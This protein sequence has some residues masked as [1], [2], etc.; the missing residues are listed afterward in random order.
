METLRILGKAGV[1]S[2]PAGGWSVDD[3]VDREVA[4]LT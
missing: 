1:V 4:R 2:E 3:F